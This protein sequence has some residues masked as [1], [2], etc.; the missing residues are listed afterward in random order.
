MTHARRPL[1]LFALTIGTL[2][3]GGARTPADEVVTEVTTLRA[4]DGGVSH[5]ILYW[6]PALHPKTVVISMHPSSDNQRHFALRPAAEHGYAGF[7]LAG[8]YTGQDG[9]IHEEV[10]LDL[11]R[12][13]KWLKEERGFTR[14][15]L[16]GHSG[17]GSRM[18][19][20]QS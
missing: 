15:V 3:L 17:G 10:L 1:V 4:D 19:Y 14:V 5:G 20:Y 2:V 16:L 18:A 13:I 6:N 7:G 9:G 8:R 11:A 12:A